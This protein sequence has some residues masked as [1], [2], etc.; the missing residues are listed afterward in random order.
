ME[1][2]ALIHGAVI[3]RYSSW[4]GEGYRA[5]RRVAKKVHGHRV[6]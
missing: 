2:A 4:I 1:K 5:A 6:A 3:S